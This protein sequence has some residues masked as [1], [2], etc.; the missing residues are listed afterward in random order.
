MSATHHLVSEVLRV[1]NKSSG[2][3]LSGNAFN[4]GLLLWFVSN[5]LFF[6]PRIKA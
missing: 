1:C 5:E 4:L 6:K 3:F 2:T